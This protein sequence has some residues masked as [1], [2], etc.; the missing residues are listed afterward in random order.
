MRGV[1]AWE[2]MGNGYVF[3]RS[4]AGSMSTGGVFLR[5]SAEGSSTALDASFI[6]RRVRLSALDNCLR[7]VWILS[8]SQA[9]QAGVDGI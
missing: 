5:P 6:L 3:L 4:A 8:P 9:H 1:E 7:S 2:T